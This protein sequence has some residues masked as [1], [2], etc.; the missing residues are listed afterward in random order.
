MLC[1]FNHNRKTSKKKKSYPAHTKFHH[2]RR[3]Q[4]TPFA[5]SNTTAVS[6]KATQVHFG[7]RERE[8][9]S[10]Q[11]LEGRRVQMNSHISNVYL[12]FMKI[13]PDR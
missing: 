11:K 8:T 7:F 4:A 12:S 2:W 3:E 5:L 9:L 1:I 13:Y 6:E 10:F